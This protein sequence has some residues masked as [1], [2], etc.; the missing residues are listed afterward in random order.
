[1]HTCLDSWPVLCWLDGEEPAAG[2]V[3]DVLAKERPAMSWINLVEVYYRLARDHGRTEADKVLAE[4]RPRVVEDLPGVVAMRAAAE[5]KADF[6]M[7][8][9]DCFA[10]ALAAE[11]NAVLLTGDPEIIDIATQLP[12]EVQDLRN[13]VT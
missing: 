6:A 8:L 4:L 5:L 13:P 3:D 12:C 7:S 1:M 10:V 11:E 2:V 9:A